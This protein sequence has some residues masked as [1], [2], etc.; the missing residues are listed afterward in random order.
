MPPHLLLWTRMRLRLDNVTTIEDFKGANGPQAASSAS[1]PQNSHL[2]QRHS[3]LSPLQR[4]ARPGGSNA[5]LAPCQGQAENRMFFSSLVL[6]QVYVFKLRPQQTRQTP[7][8]D[9]HV[10]GA[11]CCSV[12][13]QACL[14]TAAVAAVVRMGRIRTSGLNPP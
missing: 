8:R 1:F 10:Q 7:A 3:H 12:C 4:T 6:L 5:S 13:A 11:A 14:T 2:K 9:S